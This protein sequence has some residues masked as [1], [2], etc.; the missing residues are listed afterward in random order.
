[1]AKRGRKKTDGTCIVCHNKYRAEIEI[2]MLIENKTSREVEKAIK[3]NGWGHASYV[4]LLKHMREHVDVKREVTL[5]Y[6]N[7]K[8]QLLEDAGKKENDSPGMDELQV[9]LSALGKLDRSISDAEALR[10]GAAILLQ[11]QLKTRIETGANGKTKNGGKVVGVDRRKADNEHSYAPIQ[12]SAVRLY[13]V[14]SEEM[15]QNIDTKMRTLGL[16]VNTREQDRTQTLVDII[17]EAS[18]LGQPEAVPDVRKRGRKK[19]Q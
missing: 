8:K 16:D 14:A 4:T 17:L 1:M 10:R 6:L 18:P 7:E 9:K 2:M 19:K 5:H 11:E 3:E 15:R 12:D 13:K